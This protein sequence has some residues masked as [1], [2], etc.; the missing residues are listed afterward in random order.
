MLA[1][2]AAAAQARPFHI[3]GTQTTITPSSQ[4]AQVL[5][6]NGVSVSAIGPATVT[7]GT[8]TLPIDGGRAARSGQRGRVRH[9]GGVVFSK[10]NRQIALRHFVLAGN[11]DHPRLTA[12]VAGRRIVLARLSNAQHS[13]SGRTVT[14]SG[15]LL[16][17]RHAARAIDRRI[18]KQVVS[19]GTDLGSLTSTITV[20]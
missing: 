10:G 18:G 13:T 5:T 8:L 20:A 7:N 3:T 16:L 6:T 15:E 2:G 12:R 14:L 11:I 4:V 19:P 9:A 1:T 17:S